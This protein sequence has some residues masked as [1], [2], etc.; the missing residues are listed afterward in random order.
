MKIF[1]YT[2]HNNRQIENITDAN[3]EYTHR[4]PNQILTNC[5]A[6]KERSKHKNGI[7]IITTAINRITNHITRRNTQSGLVL[8]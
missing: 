1:T 7:H 2:K 8:I 5:H 6:F 3:R 4:P